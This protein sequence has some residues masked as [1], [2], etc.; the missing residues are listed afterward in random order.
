MGRCITSDDLVC[1]NS[2][3]SYDAA[4]VISYTPS[5]Y[6]VIPT[7]VILA[8]NRGA[9]PS[10]QAFRSPAM[11]THGPVCCMRSSACMGLMGACF[12][13]SFIGISIN[14]ALAVMGEKVFTH[15]SRF[16][17]VGLIEGGFLRLGTSL[18]PLVIV[19][20]A[21]ISCRFMPSFIAL[22]GTLNRKAL[23]T[24]V[25]SVMGGKD[26]GPFSLVASTFTSSKASLEAAS[27]GAGGRSKIVGPRGGLKGVSTDM[28]GAPCVIGSVEITPVWS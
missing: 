1:A 27:L 15:T 6:A 13:G 14:T 11:A 2:R 22:N 4:A 24:K 23:G 5:V 25:G 16:G 19:L 21:A 18:L 9:P 7:T 17:V 28:G 10:A 3:Y 8:S 26:K 20:N 12:S